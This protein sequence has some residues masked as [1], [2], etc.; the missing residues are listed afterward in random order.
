MKVVTAHTM[1]EIDRR[2]IKEYGIPGRDLM[3][4]AGRSCAE[5][6]IEAYGGRIS[7]KAVIVCGKGN[8]GGDGYVIA[9]KLME[10]GWQV[11]VTVLAKRSEITGD[12]LTNLVLL[13]GE[14]LSFCPGD[15]EATSRHRKDIAKAT[16]VVDAL[17]GSGLRNELKGAYLEAVRLINASAKRVV[18][19]DIPTGVHGTTGRVLGEAVNAD[20]TITFQFAKLG[21]LFYPGAKHTGKLVTV[22]IGIPEAL[23]NEAAGYEFLDDAATAQ[24]LVRREMQAHK[25]NFGHC[26][27]IAGSTGKTGAAA[28]A[29]NSAVRTGAGLVTLA[30]PE[31]IHP[32]LEIKTTEAM[33]IPLPD[34][35][36]GYLTGQAMGV[37]ETALIDK[38]SVGIGPGIDRK[39][40]TSDL[41]HR[42]VENVRIPVV[43]DADAL[44]A[45]SD[46]LTVLSR[47]KSSAIIIT[48]HPGEMSRLIGASIPDVAAVRL[49]IAQEFA[50][51]HRVYVVLK[52]ARTVIAA[53]DGMAAINGSGNPGMATGGTGDVLTG[54]ITA[55]LAQG[56]NA[57]QSCCLGV[58]LHGMAGDMVALEKGQIGMNATD[59]MESI[60]F[61][62]NRL[63]NIKPAR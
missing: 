59:L 46:D 3:E 27:I 47:S 8:N 29:A 4:S 10:N 49:S 28:L 56:Y 18:S 39:P 22:D 42:L 7:P 50:K 1:Q 6:I 60:P 9:R 31:A 20:L 40:E 13:P 51:N 5:L 25:G 37:I 26:L 41:V 53:P 35:G 54:M 61:A 14:I 55:L 43:L 63:I 62:I 34:S 57:W 33:T 52:G 16:V 15:N 17:I 58:Y 44:N 11:L 38:K 23:K 24:M 12:A 21:H 45:L 19:V 36:T 32:I 30:T 48:P 2:A